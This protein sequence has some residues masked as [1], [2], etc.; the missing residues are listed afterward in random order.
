MQG[1]VSPEE[2]YVEWPNESLVCAP[3][4]DDL[5]VDST[6]KEVFLLDIYRKVAYGNTANSKQQ[7]IINEEHQMAHIQH[8]NTMNE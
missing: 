3:T 1:N 2:R 4:R 7:L 6:V 5:L 8:T